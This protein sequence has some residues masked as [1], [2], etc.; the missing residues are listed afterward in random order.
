M[1]PDNLL[2]G[3]LHYVINPAMGWG[4]Y[5]MHSFRFGGG[6]NPIEYSGTQT[7]RDCGPSVRHE[8][9]VFLAQVIRKKG[10]TFSYEYDYGDGWQHEIKV[11]KVIPFDPTLRLPVC[12]AGERAC[13]PEDCGGV[14]GYH[15][16]LEALRQASTPAQK[17]FREWL[18]SYD[19][20][21]FDLEAINRRWQPKSSPISKG[22]HELRGRTER[23]SSY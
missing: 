21:R 2:L 4:G 13:P 16:V 6:F 22:T 8:D 9:S 23:S 5:H 17:E 11:E 20:E 7:V 18:G 1:V 3:E 14:S 10:Q 12:L 19:P 15:N